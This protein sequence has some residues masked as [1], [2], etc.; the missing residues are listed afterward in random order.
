MVFISLFFLSHNVAH[1][2]LDVFIKVRIEVD[3]CLHV[4]RTTL[5]SKA[6]CYLFPTV[7]PI[8]HSASNVFRV[9]RFCC[10]FAALVTTD[11]TN[12]FASRDFV[13]YTNLLSVSRPQRAIYCKN[14]DQKLKHLWKIHK[15]NI[16][17]NFSFNHLWPWIFGVFFRCAFR[18][19][20]CWWLIVVV[21]VIWSN[22]LAFLRKMCSD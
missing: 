18:S 6:G 16:S 21:V 11:S 14:D 15:L 8:H 17:I 1:K 7:L 20:F 5:M 10:L 4:V 22:L 9:V 13:E 19:F 3:F 12:T 2:I